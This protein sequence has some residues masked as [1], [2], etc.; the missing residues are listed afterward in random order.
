[1]QGKRTRPTVE[2]RFWAKVEK[3]DSCW[4]WIA[5]RGFGG[6]GRFYPGRPAASRAAHRVSYEWAKGPIPDG[7]ELDHL[8]RVREC[9]NPDH[10]EAVT[11]AEN[12]RRARAATAKDYCYRGHEFTPEN[13]L[14][15][16][17]GW[18]R[19]RECRGIRQRAWRARQKDAA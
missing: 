14:I 10:L 19:C 16:R 15:D 7:L 9:V 4:L 6:Y 17:D 1:M 5:S 13:T 11:H 8:C 3:T 12:V 18:R 2:E